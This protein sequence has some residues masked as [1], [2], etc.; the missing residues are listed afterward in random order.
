LASTSGTASA[1]VVAAVK[2][3]GYSDQQIVDTLLVIASITFTNLLN[4]VNDTAL[5]FPAAD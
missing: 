5:D 2:A 1:E 3:A 4:R